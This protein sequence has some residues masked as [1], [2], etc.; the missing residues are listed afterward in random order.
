[1]VFNKSACI[2]R[3]TYCGDGKVP[4]DTRT[5]KYSRK[6]TRS[7]CLKKGFGI[8]DWQHR[9]KDLSANSLQQIMYIGPVYESKFKKKRI[10]TTK[11]LINK[12]QPMTAAEKKEIITKCCTRANGSVDQK[13]VNSVLL[14]LHDKG[15]TKLPRCKI[16]RE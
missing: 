15:V 6:G 8:A 13:A 7:E 3:K 10:G 9:K 11:S 4:D 1:M 16:V 5:V 12:L 14:F 2:I